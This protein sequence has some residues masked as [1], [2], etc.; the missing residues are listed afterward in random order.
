MPDRRRDIVDRIIGERER[1]LMLP[2]SETDTIKG[3]NDWLIT[4][5]FYLS[6]AR[7][8][9]AEQTTQL[10]YED[11]LVKA[12]AIILAALEHADFMSEKGLLK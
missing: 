12:A 1:N 2:G 7:Q 6:Q 3:V 9:G 4:A 10:D 8:R 11:E 5:I